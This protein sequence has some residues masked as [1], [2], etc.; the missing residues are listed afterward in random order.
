MLK[1]IQNGRR[2]GQFAVY[3]FTQ[4][5]DPEELAEVLDP[6]TQPADAWRAYED[7][8][9]TFHRDGLDDLEALKTMVAK[10][11]GAGGSTTTTTTAA[12]A[13]RMMPAVQQRGQ[14]SGAGIPVQAQG[15]GEGTVLPSIPGNATTPMTTTSAVG[16][17]S[18][19]TLQQ[20]Y[21]PPAMPTQSGHPHPASSSSSSSNY[22][23]AGQQ[24]QYYQQQ[25]QASPSPS[26]SASEYV[27]IAPKSVGQAQGQGQ[28][29]GE[30]G[31]GA[32]GGGSSRSRS[33]TEISLGGWFRQAADVPRV[34][35]IEG[36]LRGPG[37]LSTSTAAG[38]AD[39]HQ[40]GGAAGHVSGRAEEVA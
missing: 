25:S 10:K 32:A 5:K 31:G 12:A 16:G 23:Q 7:E 11:K 3:G 19:P 20:G 40:D 15:I 37:A 38:A 13:G 17:T 29:Q 27:H 4:I 30:G 33:K 9:G 8:S 21:W 36:L 39:D 1:C 14:P 28:V 6:A 22:P 35:G 26:A 2:A 24:Q 34:G 18:Y